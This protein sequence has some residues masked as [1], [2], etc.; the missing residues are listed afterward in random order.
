MQTGNNIPIPGNQGVDSSQAISNDF[1][2][3]VIITI[4]VF[5][6]AILVTIIILAYNKKVK[7]MLELYNKAELN[8]TTETDNK[9]QD[10]TTN[11]EKRNN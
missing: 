6:V 2:V 11:E 4:L 5:M 8:E 9:P 3:G 7:K 1:W 10:D